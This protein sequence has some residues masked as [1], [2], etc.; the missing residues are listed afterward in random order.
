M[1]I[2]TTAT[3]NRVTQVINILNKRTNNMQ[4]LNNSLAYY[5]FFVISFDKNINI[6]F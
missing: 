6:H 4:V 1:N 2:N 3:D 5:L